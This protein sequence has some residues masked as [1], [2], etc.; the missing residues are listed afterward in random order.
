MSVNISVS[1]KLNSVCD[2]IIKIMKSLDINCRMIETISVIDNN[3][4]RG[5]LITYG[6]KYNSKKM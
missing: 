4:E 5:C 6:E 1:N 2:D 3:I